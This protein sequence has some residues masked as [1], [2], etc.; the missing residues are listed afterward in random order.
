MKNRIK[1]LF[2]ILT[3]LLTLV[4]VTS[5]GGDGAEAGTVVVLLCK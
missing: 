2:A 5:C 4:L 1:L 3:L